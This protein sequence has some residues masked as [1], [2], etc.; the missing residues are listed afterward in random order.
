MVLLLKL[1]F[2]VICLLFWLMTI[3][4]MISCQSPYQYYRSI[5]FYEEQVKI[6]YQFCTMKNIIKQQWL[7]KCKVSSKESKQ[8]DIK[9]N[10]WENGGHL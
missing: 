9:L 1:G 8:P 7:W 6:M 2:Q 3:I 4:S 10:M 5:N